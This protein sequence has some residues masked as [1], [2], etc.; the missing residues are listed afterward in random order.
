MQK[1]ALTEKGRPKILIVE[2]NSDDEVLLMRQLKKAELDEHIHTIR[3]GRK[4]LSFLS[5]GKNELTA[6]FLDL[7]LPNVGGL[8]ILET[9]RKKDHCKNIPIIV[10]TSSNSPEELDRCR[11]LGVASYVQKPLT[12][13]SFAKAFAD[14]FHARQTGQLP[15]SDR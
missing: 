13:S 15:A 5:D 9:L 8:Q 2:D 14:T 1:R 6:I 11:E 12:F 7:K 3:D 4:A 10:M